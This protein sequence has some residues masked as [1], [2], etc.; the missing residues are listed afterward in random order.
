M[1][2]IHMW[3]REGIGFQLFF[4]HMYIFEFIFDYIL[5]SRYT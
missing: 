1:C 2:G 5:G 3:T 4:K